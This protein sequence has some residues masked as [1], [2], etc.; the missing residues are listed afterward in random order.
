MKSNDILD[1]IGDAKGT[2][3]WDAQRIRSGAVPI[4]RQKTSPKKE[5][6]TAPPLPLPRKWH[7][8]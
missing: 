1:M 6:N 5:M 7:R 8:T 3:V 2:Y 4:A